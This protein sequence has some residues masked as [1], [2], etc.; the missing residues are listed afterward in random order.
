MIIIDTDTPNYPIGECG[1]CGGTVVRRDDFMR[2]GYGGMEFIPYY[3]REFCRR[4][5]RVPAAAKI[6]MD[7]R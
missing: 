2:D 3:L 7:N 4:C 1:S 6:E 5:G